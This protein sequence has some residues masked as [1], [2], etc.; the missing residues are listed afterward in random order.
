MS[1]TSTMVPAD[2]RSGQ[3]R[4]F[5]QR[6]SGW[7][8]GAVEAWSELRRARPVGR[9]RRLRGRRRRGGTRRRRRRRGRRRA[10]APPATHTHRPSRG[11]RHCH[12]SLPM[13]PL[14]NE[15]G[16]SKKHRARRMAHPGPVVQLHLHSAPGGVLARQ[17]GGG[18]R[19]EESVGDVAT[20]QLR[21]QRGVVEAAPDEEEADGGGGGGR[22]AEEERAPVGGCGRGR[23]RSIRLRQCGPRNRFRAGSFS[24]GSEAAARTVY[25]DPV[26]LR[27]CALCI[28]RASGADFKRRGPR[29]RRVD[30][31]CSP[32]AA[33]R[34]AREALR[35]RRRRALRRAGRKYRS[36]RGGA[37]RSPGGGFSCFSFQRALLLGARM[38]AVRALAP[39]AAACVCCTVREEESRLPARLRGLVE[40]I[41]NVLKR[42]PRGAEGEKLPLRRVR[43]R[44]PLLFVRVG[45]R[46]AARVAASA[47]AVASGV[48]KVVAGG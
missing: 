15:T 6:K 9:A 23:L 3:S 27:R 41:E 14:H 46:P 37:R 31:C 17:R 19:W 11:L 36:L 33:A 34:R 16:A 47:A 40:R 2:I 44:L 39:G 38:R 43:V 22:D 8:A 21:P 12:S 20:G 28:C 7:I 10:T 13:P 24:S 5:C 1:S 35:P 25:F 48:R 42:A 29:A 26:R 30:F 45:L 32:A 18:A 4:A